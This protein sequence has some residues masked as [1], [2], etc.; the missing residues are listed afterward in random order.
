M[1]FIRKHRLK[2]IRFLLIG[3]LKAIETEVAMTISRFGIEC[4]EM[5]L[6]L[7]SASVYRNGTERLIVIG[8]YSELIGMHF[9]VY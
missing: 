8:W 1:P 4:S 6:L 5:R 2:I 3:G 9:K 7:R